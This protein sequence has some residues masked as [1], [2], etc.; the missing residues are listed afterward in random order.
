MIDK[1]E[2]PGLSNHPCYHAAKR[3]A[4]V[5]AATQ[6]IDDVF[7]DAALDRIV[8]AFRDRIPCVLAPSAV[9]EDSKNAL[10]ITYA[11]WLANELEI[12]VCNT[13]FQLRD[14]K[15]D[16]QTVWNRLRFQPSFY[17]DVPQQVD[18]ILADDVFT[19]GG[20]LANLR[21]FIELKGSRVISM[22][23]LAHR[24][25]NHVQVA[26]TPRTLYGLQSKFGDDLNELLCDELGYEVSCLTEPEGLRLLGC[27]G[28]DQIRAALH[29]A[30]HA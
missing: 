17:G 5:L 10:A 25:G 11:Q 12:P 19:L 21:G 18:F 22:T 4:N 20:T 28:V 24:S 30:G 7:S 29:G 2:V 27:G 26:L 9:P 23:C 8:D 13:I 14:V 1:P 3:S 16:A 15:R 6:V